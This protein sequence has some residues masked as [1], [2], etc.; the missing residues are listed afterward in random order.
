M[1]ALKLVNLSKGD[2]PTDP[3][4]KVISAFW[5]SARNQVAV[6]QGATNEMGRI[7]FSSGMGEIKSS[8][9]IC[10]WFPLERSDR[11]SLDSDLRFYFES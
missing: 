2:G 1:R 3:S 4:I 11:I 8:F 7:R 10:P 6:S 5:T 9:L